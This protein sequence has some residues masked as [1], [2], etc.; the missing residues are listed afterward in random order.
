MQPTL[1]VLETFEKCITVIKKTVVKT[2]LFKKIYLTQ[3]FK[4]IYFNIFI[5]F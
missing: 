5:D 1:L 4:K 3:L 2:Q